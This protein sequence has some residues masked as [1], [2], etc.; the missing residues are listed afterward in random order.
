MVCWACQ[1]ATCVSKVSVQTQTD[2]YIA[3]ND[4]RV[5]S[6]AGK[7][8][9]GAALALQMHT[10]PGSALRG[11][12]GATGSRLCPLAV[13]GIIQVTGITVV[14]CHVSGGN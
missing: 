13:T 12:L 3:L 11:L 1:D 9:G 6:G 14:S 5:K 7:G 4:R 10:G 8:G 2:S